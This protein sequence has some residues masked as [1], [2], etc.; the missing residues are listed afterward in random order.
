MCICSGSIQLVINVMIRPT[1]IAI[2]FNVNLYRY[3]YNK[4][5]KRKGVKVRIKE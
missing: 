2:F 4:T 5:K 3:Q 1:C